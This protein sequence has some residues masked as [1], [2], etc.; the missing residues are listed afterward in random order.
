MG[1]YARAYGTY[2]CM[3]IPIIYFHIYCVSFLVVY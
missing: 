1:A 2:I 3:Y